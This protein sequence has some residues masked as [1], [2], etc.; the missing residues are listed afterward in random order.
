MDLESAH[1]LFRITLIELYVATV[2][3]R[4][5]DPL[6]K[7][8]YNPLLFK[9]MKRLRKSKNFYEAFNKQVQNPCE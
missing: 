4:R 9:E 1:F 3:F 7:I 6:N 8:V 5:E 2:L